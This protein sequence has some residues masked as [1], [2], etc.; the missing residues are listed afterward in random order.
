ML[1]RRP[2]RGDDG[3]V[4]IAVLIFLTLFAVLVVSLVGLSSTGLDEVNASERQ[5]LGIAT[6]EGAVRAAINHGFKDFQTNHASIAGNPTSWAWCR[7][8]AFSLDSNGV[9]SSVRCAVKGISVSG[10]SAPKPPWAL[11][12][13]SG[14]SIKQSRKG[15]MEIGG[16]VFSS[17]EIKVDSKGT[18]F[19]EGNARAVSGTCPRVTASGTKT[20]PSASAPV[21]PLYGPVLATAPTTVLPIPSSC[22]GS[23]ITLEAPPGGALLTDS[24]ALNALT[25]GSGGDNCSGKTLWFKPGIYRFNFTA[26]SHS[27]KIRDGNMSVIG[28]AASGG[29]DTDPNIRPPIP[30]SCIDTPSSWSSHGVQ[31]IF[32]GDSRLEVERGSI[33]LC[34]RSG[35]IGGQRNVIFGPGSSSNGYKQQTS[36]IVKTNDKGSAVFHGSLYAPTASVELKDRSIYTATFDRGIIAKNITLHTSQYSGPAVSV[37][38]STQEAQVTVDL[39]GKVGSK[40]WIHALVTFSRRGG[41]FEAGIDEWDVLR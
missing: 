11:M 20:C 27:W 22:Q 31:F 26:G 18:M 17:G 16:G 29:W 25:D 13:L 39:W 1:A 19:V 7:Q 38:S 5:R 36:V 37:P 32:D 24:S 34:G 15:A 14:G 2:A 40:D 12:T 3:I 6:S 8:N 10:D 30:G 35:G 28:G 33:E 9:T 23:I 4:L 21:D 41:S